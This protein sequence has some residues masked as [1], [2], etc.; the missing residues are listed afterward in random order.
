VNH[1]VSIIGWGKDPTTNVEYWT[2]RNS[3]G[4]YWGEEGYF[5]IQMHTDNLAIESQ[6][7]WGLPQT[8]KP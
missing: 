1:E 8:T 2:V 7:S 4:T 6:G 5:R 3:W